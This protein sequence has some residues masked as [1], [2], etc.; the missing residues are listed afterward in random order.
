MFFDTPGFIASMSFYYTDQELTRDLRRWLDE[1]DPAGQNR[2]VGDLVDA[3]AAEH[4]ITRQEVII[5]GRQIVKLL[6]VKKALKASGA[7]A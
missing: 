1:M 3:V 4:G 5:R 2:S 6:M 7:L